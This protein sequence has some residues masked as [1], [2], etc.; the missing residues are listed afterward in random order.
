M[1]AAGNLTYLDPAS[2]ALAEV[3][4]SIDFGHL[5]FIT[6]LAGLRVFHRAVEAVFQV[7]DFLRLQ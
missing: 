6:E 2:N 1:P 5:V 7:A 3:V 4:I